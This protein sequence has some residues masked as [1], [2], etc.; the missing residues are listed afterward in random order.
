MCRN[1]R[2]AG[3]KV[4][5]S[6]EHLVEFVEEAYLQINQQQKTDNYIK[7]SFELCGLNPY[8]TD[9]IVFE[10]HLASLSENSVYAAL[11]A[12]QTALTLQN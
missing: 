5:I 2:V 6:R 11:T 1:H 4:K 10:R 3:E 12:V 9:D 8:A 7:Q